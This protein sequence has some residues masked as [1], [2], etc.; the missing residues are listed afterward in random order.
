MV[1]KTTISFTDSSKTI[2]DTGYGLRHFQDGD[3]IE[4]SGSANNDGVYT[5]AGDSGNSAGK[6]TVVESLADEAAGQTVTIKSVIDQKDDADLELVIE[7]VS[8]WIDQDRSVHD[9]ARRFHSVEETRY[10][11]ARSGV[12]VVID[13]LLSITSLATDSGGDNTF[14]TTWAAADYLLSPRNALLDN[15]PYLFLRAIGSK[16]FPTGTEEV[17]V[18]GAFGYCAI[19]D[20]PKAIAEACL[21][22]SE[23]VWKRKDTIF[24]TSG[25]AQLGQIQAI[26]PLHH[27]G[28]VKALLESIPRRRPIR[29]D[30]ESRSTVSRP[31]FFT[32]ATGR[33]GKL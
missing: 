19:A 14:A 8:R 17:K 33:R 23:R 3:V 29:E 4:V 21:L 24:G 18:T 2:T 1:V 7:A 22:V 30:W 27:D 32:V 15:E 26:I 25:N 9:F 13:D 28:E 10:Y 6:I 11:T 12:I 16:S 20:V 5:V 31:T